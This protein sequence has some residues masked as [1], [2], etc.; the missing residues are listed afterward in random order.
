MLDFCVSNKQKSTKSLWSIN[1]F[2]LRILT[3]SEGRHG[4]GKGR[5]LFDLVH[6][7][8]LD[9]KISFLN[10][11]ETELIVFLYEILPQ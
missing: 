4:V 3:S 7:R 8:Q 10:N 11:F 1:L 6:V 2:L 9:I 5:V